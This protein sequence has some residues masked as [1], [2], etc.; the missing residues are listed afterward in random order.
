MKIFSSESMQP[1]SIGKRTH[2]VVIGPHTH[3]HGTVEKC[4]DIKIQNYNERYTRSSGCCLKFTTCNVWEKKESHHC[5]SSWWKCAAQFSSFQTMER[6]TVTIHRMWFAEGCWISAGLFWLL[7]LH[8]VLYHTRHLSHA[9]L[10][11]NNIEQ[12]IWIRFVNITMKFVIHSELIEFC[13]KSFIINI[14]IET[15][16]DNRLVQRYQ[17]LNNL[18]VAT[19][20]QLI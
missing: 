5:A 9:G 11:K 17:A 4:F 6:Q 8:A 14:L 20:I 2:T 18:Y 7:L 19:S 10:Y 12:L 3:T 13:C 1:R 15:I 16:C